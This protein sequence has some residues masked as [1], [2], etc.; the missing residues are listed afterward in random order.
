MIIRCFVIFVLACDLKV[1]DKF[2]GRCKE[3]KKFP[4]GTDDRWRVDER[5]V[6]GES[7]VGSF[8]IHKY[9]SDTR[10][11]VRIAHAD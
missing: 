11:T 5:V 9:D 10:D 8:G 7:D 1:N 4:S 2:T 3:I 6:D